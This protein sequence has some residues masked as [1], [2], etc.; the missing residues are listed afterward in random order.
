[1][2]TNPN[3][4]LQEL[5]QAFLDGH[6]QSKQQAGF[7]EGHLIECFYDDEAFQDLLGALACYQP[8]GGDF[9]YDEAAL[10]PLVTAALKEVKKRLAASS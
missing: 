5:L 3:L 8:G 2:K 6:D 1:M 9:L 10:L 7:L 4:R